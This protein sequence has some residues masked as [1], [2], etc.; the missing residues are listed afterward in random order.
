M[1]PSSGLQIPALSTRHQDM[2]HGNLIRLHAFELHLAE[3]AYCF[4]GPIVLGVTCDHRCPGNDVPI[5]GVPE[6]RRRR[7]YIAAGDVH[8]DQSAGNV[9][10][11]FVPSFHHAAMDAPAER[12]VGD[13][14][15]SF[16]REGEREVVRG[17]AVAKHVG[18]QGESSL[19]LITVGEAAY[20]G[21]PHVGGGRGNP[22]EEGAGVGD[23]PVSR[24]DAEVD[25]AAQGD[26]VV[27]EGGGDHEAM[28]L[29]QLPH[30]SACF[31]Q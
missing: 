12:G 18:V 5:H 4:A 10:I 3:Q 29:P 16:E 15:A 26:D 11:R 14:G 2:H 9:H 23:V 24:V 19:W 31:Y 8:V 27:N 13:P 7:R 1:D 17:A 22:G 28:E 30:A 20:H 6:Q 21:V 25:E